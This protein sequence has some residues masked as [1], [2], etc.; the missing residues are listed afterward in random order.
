MSLDRG[1]IP[2]AV[3]QSIDFSVSDIRSPQYQVPDS[4]LQMEE[5]IGGDISE[6]MSKYIMDV[7]PSVG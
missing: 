2:S 3:K 7:D 1:S 4:N 6:G 5:Y